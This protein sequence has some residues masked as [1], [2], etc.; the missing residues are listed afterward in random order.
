MNGSSLIQ[1]ISQFVGPDKLGGWIRAAVAAA[2]VA[3]IAKWP[4]FG[5]YVDS[6]TQ[7]QI[8]AAL[9]TI[10]VG[11][12]SQLMKS[13]K[14]KVEMAAAVVDPTTGKP[15]VVVTSKAL[16]DATP[17]QDNIVSHQDVVVTPK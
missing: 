1:T 2:F 6:G 5:V 10:G 8:A 4:P 13:D 11:I 14:A 12:W 16:A 17:N 9:A 3:I 7:T 15:T